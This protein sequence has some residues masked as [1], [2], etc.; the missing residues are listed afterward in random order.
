MSLSTS[1]QDDLKYG[2]GEEQRRKEAAVEA[3]LKRMKE[4]AREAAMSSEPGTAGTVVKIKEAVSLIP[5]S[6]HSAVEI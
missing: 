6:L 2:D 1:Y 3:T 4:L 5:P